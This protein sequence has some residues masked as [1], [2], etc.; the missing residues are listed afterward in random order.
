MTFSQEFNTKVPFVLAVIVETQGSTYHKAG[1][2][3]LI[4]QHG[5]RNGLLSGGCLE[6]DIC[7]HAL[8]VMHSNRVKRLS[9]NLQDDDDSVWGLGLGCDGALDIALIPLNSSNAHLSFDKV[10]KS[11]SKGERGLLE[12]SVAE[13][14]KTSMHFCT[15]TGALSDIDV[16]HQ[17]VEF[18]VS[19]QM[20]TVPVTPPLHIVICGAGPDAEPLVAMMAL[21]GWAVSIIDHRKVA[22]NRSAFVAC[23]HKVSF[24][25]ASDA[26]SLLSKADGVVIMTH[27]I[28]RDGL[29][30]KRA[31][32]ENIAYIGLLGPRARREKILDKHSVPREQASRVH[33]PIGLD[34]GGRGP[35]AIAL[36]ICAQVQSFFAVKASGQDALN[37]A[38][39]SEAVNFD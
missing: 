26:N 29:M 20:L 36:S 19:N 10:L 7:L 3:M 21:L 9:Y 2:L 11:I 35:E 31:L 22:L 13:G 39:V 27:S 25:S 37:K 23:G 30:L 1:A 17:T 33:G 24:K 5:Q 6:E 28:E 4:D 18:N 15:A 8:T 14:E 16:G 12:L 34:L 32:A 38:E